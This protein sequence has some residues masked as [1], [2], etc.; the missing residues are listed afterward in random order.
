MTTNSLRLERATDADLAAVAAL[1][2]RAYRGPTAE[3]GWSHEAALLDG[4]RTSEAMLR[5]EQAAKPEAQLLLWRR[6][7]VVAGCVWLEPVGDDRWYLGSL[8]IEPT[9]QAA[10]LGRALLAGAEAAIRSAGGRTVRM[11][12]IQL[13]DTLIAWYG[14]RGYQPTGETA[15]FPYGDH[16]FGIPR[17]NDLHFVVLEKQLFALPTD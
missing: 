8:T 9:L 14:R 13:R 16:R 5:D 12:V 7:Q 2:N 11:T 6:A 1:M 3:A 4:S 15:P 17:R 10:G